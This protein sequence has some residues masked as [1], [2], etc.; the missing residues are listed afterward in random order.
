LSRLPQIL[1]LLMCRVVLVSL[2]A[3]ICQAISE[4]SQKV[5]SIQSIISLKTVYWILLTE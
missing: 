4:P 5:F 1:L 2:L 3:S